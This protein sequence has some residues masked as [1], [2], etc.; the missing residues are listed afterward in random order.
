MAIMYPFQM[1]VPEA[2][3]G[4]LCWPF[5]RQP[6]YAVTLQCQALKAYS[7]HG[8]NGDYTSDEVEWPL[9]AK[10]ASHEW[11]LKPA[12]FYVS[13][14][15]VEA[16]GPLA[17]GK[18]LG[19]RLAPECCWVADATVARLRKMTLINDSELHGEV[20]GCIGYFS[21]KSGPHTRRRRFCRKRCSFSHGE[22]ETM[23]APY[24][25]RGCRSNI[26]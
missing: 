3:A 13:R 19:A 4:S 8:S 10:H 9:C 16:E 20:R 11:F 26:P 1:C 21:S 7:A 6:P 22:N 25:K 18:R 23:P 15:A 24:C 17:R 2:A 12:V 5:M 14:A